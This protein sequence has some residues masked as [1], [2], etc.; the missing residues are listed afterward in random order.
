MKHGHPVTLMDIKFI[1][2]GGLESLDNPLLTT[3]SLW[4]SETGSGRCAGCRCGC[5]ER[6]RVGRRSGSICNRGRRRRGHPESWNLTRG[7]GCTPRLP[8]AVAHSTHCRIRTRH[9]IVTVLTILIVC[10]IRKSRVQVWCNTGQRLL[11]VIDHG[12]PN[13]LSTLEVGLGDIGEWEWSIVGNGRT[14]VVLPA[15]GAAVNLDPSEYK[16]PREESCQHS[17]NSNKGNDTTAH[18]PIILRTVPRIRR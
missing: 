1:R 5:G 17:A 14:I 16:R 7:W 4:N 11:I 12:F 3:S 15:L 10:R 9:S 13:G 18:T 8:I 2:E 6:I